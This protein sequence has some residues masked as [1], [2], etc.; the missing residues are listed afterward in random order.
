MNSAKPSF[1]LFHS[2]RRIICGIINK[3]RLFC[4]SAFF[5][6]NLRNEV[7]VKIIYFYFST[8]L[9]LTFWVGGFIKPKYFVFPPY[10][11]SR[12]PKSKINK[13]CVPNKIPGYNLAI[14]TINKSCAKRVRNFLA[15]FLANCLN[16]IWF[17]QENTPE[18]WKT[19][20]KKDISLNQ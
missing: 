3:K 10:H 15:S 16:E 14:N 11:W 8:T 2:W 9:Y 7:R 12:V 18:I 5:R 13:K 6:A 17:F 1:S 4:Q 20:K 19:E